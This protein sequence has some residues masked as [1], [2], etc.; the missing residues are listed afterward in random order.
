MTLRAESENEL[1]ALLSTIIE[2]SNKMGLS[3]NSEKTEIMVVSKKNIT[4]DCKIEV[5]GKILKQVK[6]FKY[7]GTFVTSDGRSDTEI[8]CRIGQSKKAFNNMKN[9]FKDRNI[10]MELKLRLLQCYIEPILLYGSEAWTITKEMYKRIEA[11]EMWFI[12]RMLRVSWTERK[13]NE[14]V[15]IEAGYTRSLMKKLETRKARFFGH[16]IRRD[17][18]ENLVATGRIDGKRAPGRQRTKILD[19]LTKWLGQKRNSETIR[20]ARDRDE[21]KLMIA[22]ASKQGTR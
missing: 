21:W 11:T 22:N 18:L 5:D 16:V 9:I 12:R 14:E 3:L 8:K 2:E 13:R 1:K 17:G 10:S 4:P 15:L 7:L 19:D 6:K 20:A